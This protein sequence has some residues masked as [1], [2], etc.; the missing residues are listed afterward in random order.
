[1]VIA[2]CLGSALGVHL[3]RQRAS[4]RGSS[5]APSSPFP[6]PSWVE[7]HQRLRDQSQLAERH[8]QVRGARTEVKRQTLQLHLSPH[9]MFNALSS[10]QW[11]WVQGEARQA[12]LLFAS[13][14][15]LWQRHWRG[16]ASCVHSLKDE[17][18]TLS[19]YVAL[20]SVRLQREVHLEWDVP[21][22]R[23]NRT[24]PSLLLQPVIEN[25][26][27]HGFQPMPE[28]PRIRIEVSLLHDAL[29]PDWVSLT[30]KDN[31]K[32]LPATV[33]FPETSPTAS[34][35]TLPHP[36]GSVGL[37]VTRDRLLEWHPQAR[38]DLRAAQAPWATEAR[39]TFP[40]S[41]RDL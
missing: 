19:D 38:L 26:L 40:L 8:L 4:R 41:T 20:E 35:V 12:H 22:E 10:V 23:N 18:H 28:S 2:G 32:G 37:K 15:K 34:T 16:P 29:R 14:I 27:W 6:S 1:M 3:G 17:L 13:F 24:M 36:S 33:P 9:F 39:F 21:S 11:L 30:V 7:R 5:K 31:G 25:A